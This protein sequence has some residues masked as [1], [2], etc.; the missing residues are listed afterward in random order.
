MK[1]FSI[2]LFFGLLVWIVPFALSL[3]LEPLSQSDPFVFKSL[4]F[5]S[6]VVSTVF[7]LVLYFRKIF[8]GFAGEGL[9]AGLLWLGVCLLLDW[10][11]AAG[12]ESFRQY[13]LSQG[14]PFISIP[15]IS[16]GFDLIVKRKIW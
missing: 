14:L 5:L 13:F 8:S 12:Q 1:K 15:V 10:L 2:I 6:L 7:F 11:F 4:I 16:S 3:L 9:L